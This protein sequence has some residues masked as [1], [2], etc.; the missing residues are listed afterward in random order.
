MRL[1]QSLPR[2]PLVLALAVPACAHEVAPDG[3]DAPLPQEEAA[4]GL[5][6]LLG[7]GTSDRVFAFD[8]YRRL[9]EASPGKNLVFSPYS[10]SN[11]LAMT[12]AGA[13]GATAAEMRSTLRFALADA[14]QH[15]FYGTVRLA[16]ASRGRDQVGADGTPFRL[17]VGNAIWAQSGHPFA[18]PFLDTAAQHYGAAPVS[19]DFASDPAA[20][21]AVINARVAEDT[22]GLIP[23]LLEPRHITRETRLVLTNTVYFNASWQSPFEPRATHDAPFTRLDGTQV[24]A[25]LMQGARS[26]P[27]A[28]GPGYQAVALPYA[29]DDLGFFAVLPDQG[30]FAEVE[31]QASQP[32]LDGVRATLRPTSLTLSLPKLDYRVKTSLPPHLQAL[33][34]RA[35]F[36]DGDFSGIAGQRMK[37][38]DVVH[39][40]VLKV[41]EGG[42]I[43]AAATAVIAAPTAARPQPLRVTFDRPFLFAIFDRPTGQLLFLGRVTDPTAR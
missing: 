21:R 28:R 9:A 24:T 43:A 20:A 27:Y 38:A 40:A 25:K 35:A 11:A 22:E 37:I 34:M 13:R 23:E 17:N 15:A 31:A 32:W 4:P 29:S 14:E 18:Q 19:L 3:A 42:T 39:E 12:Y 16:L 7:P 10:I 30:K 1:S 26:I 41:F 6:N 5:P 8:L 2:L 33:G 36:D